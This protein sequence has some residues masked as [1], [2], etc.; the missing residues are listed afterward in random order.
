MIARELT[1]VLRRLRARRRRRSL[2]GAERRAVPVERQRLLPR[3][4]AG[5][6][7]ASATSPTPRTRRSARD[8]LAAGWL[9]VYH[10]GA[11][12]CCTRTTTAR[13][14]SCAATSTSTAACARRPATSRR[15]AR[16]ARCAPCAPRRRRDLRWMREQRRRRRRA[17]ALGRAL[18]V[19]HGG[20]RVFSALGSRAERLPGA[21]AAAALA[22]RARGDGAAS[23]RAARRHAPP[24]RPIAP[25]GSREPTTPTPRACCATARRRCSTRSRAWPSAS[26]CGSRCV[27]PAV[28]ARQRRP[29]HAVSD[30]LLAARAPR[31]RLQRLGPRRA[32]RCTA[33]LW[34]AVLRHDIARV[35]RAARR[36]RSTRASTTGTAPTS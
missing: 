35:L 32:G 31:P 16:S 27:D 7:S 8:L 20:R 5:S 1:R 34:P 9:K 17:R 14:S 25:R 23:G 29:Q 12:R 15:S 19:H 3:A 26:A 30:L 13:S 21:R 10:P 4:R 6:R 28:P 18:G 22:G 11:R 36:R 24:A 2:Q 33:D